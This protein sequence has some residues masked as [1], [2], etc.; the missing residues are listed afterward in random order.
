VAILASD[1]RTLRHDPDVLIVGSGP[2]GIAAARH[3]A[4]GGL[5]VTVVEAGSA[6]TEP[7]GSHFRNQARFW[8][9][10]D[11]FFAS[12]DRYFAPIAGDLPGAADS[13]LVGGQGI[14]WTNNCPRAAAFE[15][16]D[17][18]TAEQWEQAYAAAE[19]VLQVMPDPTAASRTGCAIRDRLQGVLAAEG[20]AI[21]GL[22]LSGRVLPKGEIYFNGPWD[23]LEAAA[24]AARKRIA[25]RPGVRVTRLRYRDG[26]VKGI[27]L[28]GPNDGDGLEAPMVLLAGG[29]VGTA[30]LLQRSGIRPSAL[31]RGISFHALLFGQIVLDAGMCP[32][33]G[34]NDVAPRHWIPP[35]RAAP[36][37]VQ[38]LRDTCPLTPAEVVDNPH[39][40]LEFQ[41]FLPVE[42]REENALVMDESER[43]AFRFA[44]SERDRERMRA[45]EADVRRLAE[46]LGPWRR[47]C[48]PTWL[49]HGTGHLVGTCRMDRGKWPG[50][51]DRLGKV[52]GFENLYLSTV[53]MFP[54]PVAVNPTL[55]AL[56][57]ALNT[58]EAI[59]ANAG[60]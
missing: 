17:A 24:P 37:H 7:P 25:V 18:M 48:E 13:S 23:I 54:A 40:L 30:R 41:A 59:A 4:E 42:F 49:P 38:V 28:V 20:R 21:Q 50:V 45:M 8:Q 31:G 52:H 26:R 2:L 55:T 19:D 56:A 1:A 15:R 51:T 9:D 27:D 3:L 5:R 47:G 14:L 44:F 6:I 34:E 12:I 10:P 46:Y 58:C 22:P 35:T 16:W 57:L 11:S 33:A 32:P 39:R 60:A 36:W 43:A 29:A 53:G